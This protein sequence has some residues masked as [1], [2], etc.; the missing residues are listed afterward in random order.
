MQFNGPV[1]H[2]FLCFLL[3]YFVPVLLQAADMSGEIVAVNT[4]LFYKSLEPNYRQ[5][6]SARVSHLSL[7]LPRFL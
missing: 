6:K 1:C 5:D 4:E 7:D 2:M 3:I